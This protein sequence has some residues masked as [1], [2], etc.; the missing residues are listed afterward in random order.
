MVKNYRVLAL[1]C[2]FTAGLI[3][4]GTARALTEEER[5]AQVEEWDKK[6][7]RHATGMATDTSE[8]VLK[9]PGDYPGKR[10]FVVAKTAPTIDFAPIRGLH[11]EYFPEDNKGNWSQWGEV[12]KG[13]NGCFYMDSGDHRCKNAQVYITEYDP[14][15]KVQRNVVDVGK[16]CGWRKGQ[17]VDGKIHGRMDILPDGTLVAATWLGR[18]VRQDDLDHGYVPGGYLLT[19]NVFTGMAKYHGVPF[20]GDSWPYHS[21]DRQTG[22]MMAVGNYGNFM[23]Y[24]V[25][26]DRL[27]YGG[28]PAEGVRWNTRAMLLDE[29]TGC[30]YG[31]NTVVYHSSTPDNNEYNFVCYDQ[32][33][34]LFS[35]LACTI[36]A[37][38]VTGLCTNLRAYS[39]RRTPEGFFWCFDYQGTMF[40]FYPD[41]EK[42]EL[43]GV[44]WDESGVYIATMAMSPACR[45]LYYVAG[46]STGAIKWGIPVIQYDTVTGTKKVIA[47]LYRYY[48]DTYGYKTGGTFGIELSA[49]GSL[50]VIQTNGRFGPR[51]A[52]SSGQPGIF[53]VHI[54]ESERPE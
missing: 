37:N 51:S 41:E 49:D 52:G 26:E 29:L 12:T 27:L 39:A 44:N 21:I 24:N 9:I 20:P 47:F 25:L 4:G 50:L 2:I 14:V 54:P 16:V 18:D 34:N 46:S 22:V 28:Q 38:P 13:P 23:A 35:H 32:R 3:S 7:L 53:A 48:H 17:Y 10:D 42:T 31:T 19:Y 15:K 11:L 45:Y 1:V 33:T 36:P 8:D 6:N 43:V 40:K 5:K 30:V